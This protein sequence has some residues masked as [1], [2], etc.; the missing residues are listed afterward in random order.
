MRKA[1]YVLN[2]ATQIYFGTL[3]TCDTDPIL[4]PCLLVNAGR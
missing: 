4:V 2:L 1:S 3:L